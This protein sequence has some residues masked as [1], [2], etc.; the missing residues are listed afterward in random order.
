MSRCKACDVILTEGELGK[1][2]RYSGLHLDLCGEC[3]RV[4]DDA[5]EGNWTEKREEI[6]TISDKGVAIN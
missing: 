6:V 2:D 1:I 4:S 5:L 3:H